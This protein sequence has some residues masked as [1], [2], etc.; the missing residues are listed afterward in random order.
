MLDWFSIT[1]ATILMRSSSLP[2]RAFCECPALSS[3]SSVEIFSGGHKIGHTQRN[4]KTEAKQESSTGPRKRLNTKKKM[5]P[6][7]GF[8]PT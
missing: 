7:V 2:I 5:V 1:V 3:G 8:E 4:A 6:G